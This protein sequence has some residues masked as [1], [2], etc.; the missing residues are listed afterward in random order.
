MTGLRHLVAMDRTR[1]H[2]GRVIFN[3]AIQ[4][5]ESNRGLAG[6]VPAG[7]T[8]RQRTGPIIV[9]AEMLE[10]RAAFRTRE[11]PPIA[12]L[13]LGR[14]VGAAQVMEDQ[15]LDQIGAAASRAALA[16]T[17]PPEIAP[18]TG[19][20]HIEKFFVQQTQRHKVLRMTNDAG[21]RALVRVYDGLACFGIPAGLDPA[22]PDH[23]PRQQHEPRIIR[24]K[25]R[26]RQRAYAF[27]N[28][29]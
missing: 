27:D 17:Q 9:D 21:N 8:Y 13:V 18:R 12:E 10:M 1:P 11:S 3:L 24:G 6:S 28:R 26:S 23:E 2:I 29:Y 14:L 19:D 4:A 15:L 7:S 5:Q 25:H 22:I 16:D 20:Q